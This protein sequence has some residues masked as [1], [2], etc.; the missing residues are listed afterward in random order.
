MNVVLAED[1]GPLSTFL[2]GTLEREGHHVHCVQDGAQAR[3][4]VLEHQPD[5]L[6]LDLGMPVLSGVEVLR[7]LDGR[8]ANTSIIVL[9]GRVDLSVK[10]ECLNLGADDYLTKPFSTQELSARCRAVRRRRADTQVTVLQHGELLLNRITREVSLN[11]NALDFTTKEFALLEYLLLKRGRPVSRHELLKQVWRV[12]PDAGTN[13]VDV[14]I[15]YLRRKLAVF[16]KSDL[17]ETLRGEGYGI[18]VRSG[19]DALNTSALH[20]PL[21]SHVGVV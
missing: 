16:E 14:Y 3:D 11:G 20:L 1:D 4:V 21:F 18:G 15:N 8:A 13:V 5:L 12:T 2:R 9:T 7:A 19:V 10:L 17:I 6:I